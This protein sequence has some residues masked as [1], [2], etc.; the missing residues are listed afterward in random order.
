MRTIRY[1]PAFLLFFVLSCAGSPPPEAPV[2]EEIVVPVP[3][4]QAPREYYLTIVAAGDNLIHDP[5]LKACFKDGGY[6]F[7]SVYDQIRGYILPADIAFVNQET[8]LGNDTLGYSGY[9]LFC[10]PPE[11]GA[12]LIA[13]GFNVINHASNHVM[14]R[15]EAGI[16]SSIAYWDTHKDVHYLG[17]H[18]SEDE[19]RNRQVIISKNNFRVGFLA[20]TFSTNGIPL[21]RGKSHLVS[22]TENEKM[23]AEIDALRPLC[24]YLV[25][26]MHWGDEYLLAASKEQKRFAAFLAEHRVDLVIGHHPHVLGPLEIMERPD[27]KSMTVF[28]SLGNFFSAHANPVKEALL[29]GLMYV[30]LK[31]NEGEI[32]V[33]EVSLIPVITH[34]ETDRSDFTIYPLQEYTKELAAKHWKRTGDPEM[35][36]NYFVDKSR[37]LFGDACSF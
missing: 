36:V 26:S 25:V 21:P 7:D 32:S 23:A 31:K 28:Y 5:I 29:G 1:K 3:E 8:I 33:E 37:E 30:R 12:A 20:Y 18:R 24:D 19:R 35:T 2:I 15:G 17:I 4:T 16:L 9:P 34:Y 10:T 13:A 27:G 11:A 14:D 22:V 6:S